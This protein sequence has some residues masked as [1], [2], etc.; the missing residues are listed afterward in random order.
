MTLEQGKVVV[1]RSELCRIKS[2]GMYAPDGVNEREYCILT[3]LASERS[4]YY[5]PMGCAQDK[6]REPLTRGEVLSLIDE[7][8]GSGGE[9]CA[10]GARRKARQNEILSSG[11]YESL[12]K[13]A[14]AIYGEQERR[15]STGKKL[16]SS[17]ERAM[18]AAEQM[19][20]S[21]FAYAL[22]IAPEEVA[23]FIENRL[24]RAE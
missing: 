22:G 14:G 23:G 2:I 15:K 12:I 19:I 9:W 20:N 21:E 5:V 3:P 10:D 17:D 7:M 4:T 13:M 6:L 16:P 11:S 1:Y 24:G 18:K 8:R